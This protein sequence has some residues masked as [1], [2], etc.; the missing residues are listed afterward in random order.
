MAWWKS[1]AHFHPQISH[2]LLSLMERYS[3]VSTFVWQN[4]WWLSITSDQ[5]DPN[6][7]LIS[8]GSSNVVVSWAFCLKLIHPTLRYILSG[9]DLNDQRSKLLPAPHTNI[10]PYVLYVVRKKNSLSSNLYFIRTNKK[11]ATLQNPR[12]VDRSYG[13]F[14]ILF[15]NYLCY[16]MLDVFTNFLLKSV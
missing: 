11:M 2:I 14:V 4:V 13:L 10:P 8:K 16:R 6:T 12:E 5:V 3:I 9:L 1:T 15:S 7:F